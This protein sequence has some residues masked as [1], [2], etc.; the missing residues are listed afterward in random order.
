MDATTYQFIEGLGI[1]Q[2]LHEFL[3]QNPEVTQDDPHFESEVIEQIALVVKQRFTEQEMLVITG[4]HN[5][6]EGQAWLNKNTEM[7]DDIDKLFKAHAVAKLSQQL[8]GELNLLPVTK[9][10]EETVN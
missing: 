8:F 7:A 5:S 3:A 9:D 6:A 2:D 10:D 4:F 1:I